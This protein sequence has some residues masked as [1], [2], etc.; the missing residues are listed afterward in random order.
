M[1]HGLTL[2]AKLPFSKMKRA[3][4]RFQLLGGLDA[5]EA[6]VQRRVPVGCAGRRRL[7]WRVL[8]PSNLQQAGLPDL[9]DGVLGPRLLDPL[10][11]APIEGLHVDLRLVGRVSRRGDDQRDEDCGDG[12]PVHGL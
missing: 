4:S 2:N 1:I 12:D 10:Q 6:V 5:L 3:K 7:V 9:G 8:H 11:D